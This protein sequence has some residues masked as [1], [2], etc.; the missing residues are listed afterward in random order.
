MSEYD[1]SVLLKQVSIKRIMI[2]KSAIIFMALG[3]FIAI[4]SPNEYTASVVFIPQISKNEGA[5]GSGFGGLAS[6]AGI[7]VGGA[8]GSEI[9]PTL[10]PMLTSSIIFKRDLINTPLSISG[11]EEKITYATYYKE[12]FSPSVLSLVKRYTLGLP[13]VVLNSFKSKKKE[14]KIS[15]LSDSLI[16]ISPEELALFNIMNSQLKV[17]PNVKDGYV[18][19]AFVM[20][21]PLLAAQMTKSAQALLQREVISFKIKNAKEQLKFTQQRFDV[22][23]AEFDK[24]QEELAQFRD[25]NR[26]ISTAIAQNGLESI[27]SEYDFAFKVYTQL[28]DQ[29]EQAKT[30]V[31]KDTPIFSVI[32]PLTVPVN[33]SAPK[34]VVILASFTLFGAMFAIL[35]VLGSFFLKD[36]INH[37]KL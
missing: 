26:K 2:L 13:G 25:E 19:L 1:L 16:R 3:I 37:K 33:K 29:L 21:D 7:N 35:Y 34:R 20:P 22:K 8:S 11:L 10:Y 17:D 12:Y 14:T 15:L 4:F 27:Q 23:K 28:A 9:P 31:S 36:V 5:G 24:I 18:R 32:Q 30:Q 6:I